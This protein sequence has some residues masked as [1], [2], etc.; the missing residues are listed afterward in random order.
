MTF[1]DLYKRAM[2][3]QAAAILTPEAEAA[4]VAPPADPAAAGGM[5]PQGADPAAMGAPQ[6][7]MDPAMAGGAPQQGAAQLPP[8]ILQ[9]QQFIQLLMQQGLQF[10]PNTATFYGPD[11]QPVPP[12]IIMQAY[13]EYQQMMAQGGGVPP[14]GADPAA[15]GGQPPMDPAM[16]G[17]MPPQG[18]ADPAMAGGAPMDPSMQAEPAQPGM[19][20]AAAGG[21]PQ[22]ASQLMP[23]VMQDQQFVQ[24]LAEMAG[25]QLDPNSG[26]FIGPDGQPVPPEAVMQAYEGF[27]QAA[28]GQMEQ[29]GQ[30]E[31]AQGAPAGASLDMDQLTKVVETTVGN[32]MA[33]LDKKI[34]TLM[35][36]IEA[37]KLSV[38]SMRDTNDKRD[39]MDR[40]A[41]KD[42][43]DE[44]A[45]E[46]NPVKK[47]ASVKKR[48]RAAQPINL[49]DL[50]V[51]K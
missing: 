39:E 10:D 16:A 31:A 51:K 8:E 40:Q 21:M 28:Q 50:I 34:E 6:P 25:I 7:G 42:A 9:D 41:L 44:I 3:K 46:L 12:E 19:D 23:E 1:Y 4:A 22:D 29:P 49:F 18:A 36:K 45:A 24:Y 5:P 17:G 35:D 32:Y 11:G 27:A 37:M 13:Q 33:Q 30:E 48:A 14:Q 2:L 38:E 20:P 43:Q 15:M 26:T 47:E